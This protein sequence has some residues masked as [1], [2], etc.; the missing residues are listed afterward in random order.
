MKG[1]LLQ[2]VH[3]CSRASRETDLKYFR[4]CAVPRA[5]TR[6]K[7][8]KMS[9]CTHVL[10]RKALRWR[11]YSPVEGKTA[12]E[13]RRR[14]AKG[15]ERHG[16]ACQRKETKRR[17]VARNENETQRKRT[18]EGTGAEENREG[19]K[20]GCIRGALQGS[21]RNARREQNCRQR[22]CGKTGSR[23]LWT[24]LFSSSLSPFLVFL[25]RSSLVRFFPPFIFIF[26]RS[27]YPGEKCREKGGARG[28]KNRVALA[29]FAHRTS[30]S[31]ERYTGMVHMDLE[32]F[33][34][35]AVQILIK[36]NIFRMRA[37]TG[38]GETSRRVPF[39]I[40]CRRARKNAADNGA[41]MTFS[42]FR[43]S[44]GAS[45]ISSL[46]VIIAWSSNFSV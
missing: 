37:P 3:G 9:N 6:W 25:S 31:S 12:R 17:D 8:T 36:R 23:S 39:L 14:D 29:L 44:P 16:A 20:R 40:S 27:D 10:P 42:R 15:A 28:K 11:T 38:A 5:G 1:A 35:R 26:T 24:F 43:V 18:S 46:L 34:S 30:Y 45:L 21:F 22:G 4:T 2:R 19:R 7:K 33:A 13:K 32:M 41:S